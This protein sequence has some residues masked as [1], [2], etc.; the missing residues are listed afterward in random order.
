MAPKE[1]K[2]KVGSAAPPILGQ[3]V[4]F[5]KQPKVMALLPPP[6]PKLEDCRFSVCTKCRQPRMVAIKPA[7][8][9][10]KIAA[11]LAISKFE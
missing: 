10:A 7:A 11:K 5:R 9:P 8:S 6:A 3:C 1:P 4:M 2:T